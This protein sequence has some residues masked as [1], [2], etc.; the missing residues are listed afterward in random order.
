MTESKKH[1]HPN[2]AVV[3]FLK[4]AQYRGIA[5]RFLTADISQFPE[6]YERL[7]NYDHGLFIFGERGVGKTHLM[8]ALMKN[9]I[10]NTPAGNYQVAELDDFPL[11]IGVPELLHLMRAEI[12]TGVPEVKLNEYSKVS[13]LYLD[14]LGVEKCSEWVLQ[15]LYLLIDRRYSAML[16]T[17]ISSNLDLN[18]ISNRLSDRISSRIAGMC[19]VLKMEGPDRR[20]K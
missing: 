10:L 16:K 17:V 1:Y 8:A 11:M 19:K 15:T 20:L 7:L 2:N 12:N 14:D 13:V 5:K 3:K 9:D 6:S 4:I 18:K